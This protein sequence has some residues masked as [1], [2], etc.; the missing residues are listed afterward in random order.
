MAIIDW[1]KDLKQLYFPPQGKFTLVDV[2]ALNFLMVDGHGDPNTAT[3]YTDA[4]QA[5]YSMA[6]TVKFALKPQGVE[7]SVAPLE[8]LWW[9]PDM[10]QFSDQD[11]S[12]WDWTMMILQ[13][14]AV[15]SD[16]VDAARA[17]AL[18]KKGLP[19]L[20]RVRL[21]MYHEGPSVQTLYLGPYADEGPTIAAMHRYAEEQGYALR[22]KHHEIYMG[23]PRRSA[24]EKLKTVIRQPVRKAAAE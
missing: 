12:A 1:K 15:T 4:I 3:E 8:G 11:K 19:A 13:P 10:A 20:E 2:P 23:D 17:E 6:Y 21:E 14:D 18:K 16:V 5:L 24:P 7:F 9:T 22:G